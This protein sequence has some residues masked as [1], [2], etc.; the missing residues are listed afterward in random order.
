MR[1][2]YTL[3]FLLFIF[4]FTTTAQAQFT[5]IGITAGYDTD[6]V[7][8]LSANY[9]A[10]AST[11]D[12]EGVDFSR[13]DHSNAYSMACENA[14]VRV[15]TG[16][17]LPKLNASAYFAL[18]GIFNRW[19]DVSYVMDDGEHISYGSIGHEV[20]FESSL[21]KRYTLLN[22]L[23]LDLGFGGNDVVANATVADLNQYGENK[24]SLHGRVFG[25]VGAG[26]IFWDKVEIGTAFRY[27]YGL[28]SHI[29]GSITPTELISYELNTAYRFCGISLF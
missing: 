17:E 1:V 3:P 28:R 24:T 6:L 19:D 12:V 27:G 13:F 23:Y 9:I 25:K 7:K 11:L 2:N 21:D 14:H 29:G 26:M 20:A 10:G 18:V 5:K 4:I 15:F 8:H 22:F 16:Y